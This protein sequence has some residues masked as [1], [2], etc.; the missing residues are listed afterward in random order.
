METQWPGLF[1][2]TTALIMRHLSGFSWL[3]HTCGFGCPMAPGAYMWLLKPGSSEVTAFRVMGR[4]QFCPS[5]ILLPAGM[6]LTQTTT[7]SPQASCCR[8]VG[9]LFCRGHWKEETHFWG[10]GELLGQ[11]G[12]R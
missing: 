9:S 12:Q 8:E 7:P 3:L 5:L 11:A 2:R 4:S 1:S 10:M 6:V